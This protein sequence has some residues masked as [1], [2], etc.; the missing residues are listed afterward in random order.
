MATVQ[1]NGEVKVSESKKVV[2]IWEEYLASYFQDGSQKTRPAKR[3]W[4][5]WFNTPIAIENGD[6]LEV[7]GELSTRMGTYEKD[8]EIK[9]AVEHSINNPEIVQLKQIP[10]DKPKNVDLDDLAKYG[11]APF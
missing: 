8:G 4:T 7:R 11:H 5:I 10:Q 3:K 9:N 6:F 1:I 2:T